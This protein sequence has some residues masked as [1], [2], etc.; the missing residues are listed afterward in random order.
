[1]PRVQLSRTLPVLLVALTVSGCATVHRIRTPE[2]ADSAYAKI[3]RRAERTDATVTLRSGETSRVS[4]LQMSPDS[5]SWRDPSSTSRMA[6][7]TAQIVRVE[8]RNR[9]AGAGRGAGIGALS[10]A[11][12]GAFLGL[13]GVR[14]DP[15][16][17]IA[18]AA[19]FS[20]FGALF[21]AMLYGQEVYR[22]PAED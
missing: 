12:F 1:M 10:G 17:I 8:L 20:G 11:A 16:L 19:F 14:F 2:G 4:S 18:P 3:T 13:G 15:S 21:G 5:T 9:A 7:G 6:F 22:F